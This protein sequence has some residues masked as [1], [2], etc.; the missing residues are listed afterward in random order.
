MNSENDKEEELRQREKELK[1]REQAIRLR[2]M[3]AELYRPSGTAEPPLSTTTKH[4]ESEGKLQR[5]LKYA[6][7]VAIFVA[8]VVVA[9]AAVK[10]ATALAST[11]IVLGIAWFAYKIFFAGDRKKGNNSQ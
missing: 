9:A 10:I 4:Q 1:D 3:E 7:N 11:V 5:R 6:K 8:I 2:E